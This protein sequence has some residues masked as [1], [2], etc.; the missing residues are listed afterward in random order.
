[1]K[2]ASLLLL[3]PAR[4]FKSFAFCERAVAAIEF[5][6]IA[7]AMLILFC[8]GMEIALFL[9]ASYQT[10]QAASTVADVI[11][12]YDTL[13]SDNIDAL[14]SVASQVVGDTDF[15]EKGEIILSSISRSSGGTATIAWQ[16]TGGGQYDGESQIG[17]TGKAATLPTSLTLASDDNVIIAEVYFDY[18]SVFGWLPSS[19]TPIYK[20]SIFRPRLGSLTSAPGC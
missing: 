4:F 11:T 10:A 5:A 1:M 14:L 7:P 12:R 3:L 15:E 13:N 17:K 2:R 9:H 6:L 18:A 19:A 20:T 16:C 8:G